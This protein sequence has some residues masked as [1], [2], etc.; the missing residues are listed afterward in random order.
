MEPLDPRRLHAN[1]T[2]LK[3]Q[4]KPLKVH[5]GLLL[6]DEARPQPSSKA[7]K[8]TAVVWPLAECIE[9]DVVWPLA[10]VWPIGLLAAICKGSSE[11]SSEHL[12]SSS[13][14]VRHRLT[15]F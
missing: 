4:V 11:E 3:N 14:Q 15:T 8:S 10:V 6:R 2:P 7:A 9:Q 1:G 12:W 13:A 5:K